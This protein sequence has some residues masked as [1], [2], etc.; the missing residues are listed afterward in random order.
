MPRSP[1]WPDQRARLAAIFATRPRDAWCTLLEGTDACV[2]PV[3]DLEEA[4]LHPH[5][6]ARQTFVVVD[7]VLQPAPAP[8]LSRTPGAI[9]LSPPGVEA[10]GVE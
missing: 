9:R 2:S 1:R 4:P 7:D 10:W 5:N 8:R 3:L 6:L